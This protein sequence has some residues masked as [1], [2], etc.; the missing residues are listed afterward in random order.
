MSY[1]LDFQ[2]PNASKG[3]TF[4]AGENIVTMK[5]F[6]L[7]PVSTPN[8]QGDVLDIIF[9]NEEGDEYRHRI[10]PI[11]QKGIDDQYQKYLKKMEQ[12]TK[13]PK[14]KETY[15]K[16]TLYA[17]LNTQIKTFVAEYI[18]EEQFNDSLKAWQKHLKDTG[19]TP[20][21]ELFV[22][23]CAGVLRKYRPDFSK[24]PTKVLM[25]YKKNSV[26]L[27][28]PTGIKYN[29]NQFIST[30]TNAELKVIEGANFTMTKPDRADKPGGYNTAPTSGTE[31]DFGIE[32]PAP[33]ISDDDMPF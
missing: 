14:D 6:Q 21:F 20:T 10:F 24:V 9:T 18:S 26:Y 5:S 31:F 3:T 1:G 16:E 28:M 8:Y 30:D 32:E 7:E 11:T 17:P 33:T 12:S 13:T 2:D 25:A 29:C 22:G 15:A 27:S 4:V 19:T 23:F